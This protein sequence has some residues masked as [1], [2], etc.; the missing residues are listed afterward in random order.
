VTGNQ[1]T[2]KPPLPLHGGSLRTVPGGTHS[3]TGGKSERQQGT[4]KELKAAQVAN[5]TPLMRWTNSCPLCLYPYLLFSSTELGC[6]LLAHFILLP[7]L[8]SG[9]KQL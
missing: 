6:F 9:H 4:V 7:L 5:S 3:P 2:G 1:V 8:S